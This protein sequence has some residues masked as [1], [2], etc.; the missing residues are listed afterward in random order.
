[1]L[2]NSSALSK[3]PKT[4][5][6]VLRNSYERAIGAMFCSP[7]KNKVLAF[8]YPFAC[9]RIFHTWFCP[10]LRILCFDGTG[11]L[12][13]NRLIE[14]WQWV[15]L[16]E[17]RLVLELDP[18]SDN[19]N[20]V[21]E[22]ERQGIDEWISKYAHT[23][24]LPD[25]GGTITE[26]PY[27]ELLLGLIGDS[28]AQLRS[29]K[30]MTMGK[31]RTP[32]IL[33]NL[34]PWRRGQILSAALFVLDFAGDLPYRI[35]PTALQLSKSLVESA[36]EKT[37]TELLAAS[38]AGMPWEFNDANC[39][40]C[41]RKGVWR[42]WRQVIKPSA[43][44]PKSAQ[45]RFARPENYVPICWNC[46]E[47]VPFEDTDLA[48]A[49]GYAYWGCR[50]EAFHR[51]SENAESSRLPRDWDL[52]DFPLWPEG[53]GGNTWATGSGGIL[54]CEPRLGKVQRRREHIQILERALEYRG[55]RPHRLSPHGELYSI[56]EVH[57]V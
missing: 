34:P 48:I 6:R 28:M 3:E 12:S 40:R 19:H 21:E 46:I 25:T 27:G 29:V 13:Y 24:S 1:M 52:E 22:I 55:F 8:V 16:P 38:I 50:F 4:T 5:I 15:R 43:K 41:G 11:R 10:R 45:W 51:W 9:E 26:D 14:P 35:P 47:V 7:L 44:I 53:Y 33:Q 23:E 36:D 31:A 54:Y 57:C 32:E 49:F 30:N 2:A 17:T 18:E 42:I 56:L 39:F 20:L 37:Q